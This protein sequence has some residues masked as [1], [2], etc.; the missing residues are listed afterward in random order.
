MKKILHIIAK[1]SPG[2]TELK[3]LDLIKNTKSDFHHEILVISNSD[4]ELSELFKKEG[5]KVSNLNIFKISSLISSLV[6]LNRNY[7]NSSFNLIVGWLYPVSYT[8]L[9]AHET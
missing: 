2:G 5:V 6:Y 1:L 8:H 4:S 3:L 9:R 7:R